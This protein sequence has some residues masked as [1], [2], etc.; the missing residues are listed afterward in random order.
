MRYIKLYL[1]DDMVDIQFLHIALE[2]SHMIH[3]Y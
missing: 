2:Q 1:I 3:H